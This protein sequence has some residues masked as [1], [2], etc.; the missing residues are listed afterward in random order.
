MT[1]RVAIK[2]RYGQ[3]FCQINLAEVYCWRGEYAQARAHYQQALASFREAGDPYGEALA[4]HGLGSVD[5][6]EGRPAA[7]ARHLAAAAGMLRGLAN[8][9]ALG[10]MLVDLGRAHR[11]Q[12][13][14]VQALSCLYEGLYLCREQGMRRRE[15][16]Y[17]RELSAVLATLVPQQADRYHQQSLAILGE[18]RR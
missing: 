10:Y 16:E 1:L 2:D 6:Q 17:L 3:A 14:R 15:A 7:A 11:Q 9:S 4:R 5:E 12:G 8:R 18:L 13:Q